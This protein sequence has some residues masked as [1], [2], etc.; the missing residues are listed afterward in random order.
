M[1]TVTIKDRILWWG[2][3]IFITIFMTL[4]GMGQFDESPTVHPTN[5]ESSE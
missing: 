4:Y 5:H 3:L 1:E 2:A